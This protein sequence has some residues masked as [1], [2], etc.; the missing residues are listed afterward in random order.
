[1][2]QADRTPPVFESGQRLTAA[3]L[4]SLAQ[5]V[6]R[7]IDQRQ[8][9]QVIQPKPLQAILVSDL[10]AAVDSLTDPSTAQAR[11]LARKA[12]GDLEISTREETVVNRF[13]NISIDADTYIKIEW[14]DGEWQ[15]Y[16]A[17]CGPQSE[18]FSFGSASSGGPSASAGTGGP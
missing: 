13:E 17:D 9:T 8:G 4:N 11:I 6:A 2:T 16:A 5:S 18:S 7:I 10:L 1:M 12:N 14:I 3:A 15:P